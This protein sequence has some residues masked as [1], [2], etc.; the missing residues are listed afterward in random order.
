MSPSYLT[1]L[2]D[3]NPFFDWYCCCHPHMPISQNRAISQ[4]FSSPFTGAGDSG[5]KMLKSIQRT[6][7]ATEIIWT[8]CFWATKIFQRPVTAGTWITSIRGQQPELFHNIY[9]PRQI[10]PIH[11]HRCLHCRRSDRRLGADCRH[12]GSDWRGQQRAGIQTHCLR[13][14]EGPWQLGARGFLAAWIRI[15]SPLHHLRT[16]GTPI[17]IFPERIDVSVQCSPVTVGKIS[18]LFRF[19]SCCIHV[20]A[21][22]WKSGTPKWDGLLVY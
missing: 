7:T 21:C 9:S 13:R 11:N 3:L 14:F 10:Q 18:A 12:L 22:G 15:G 8:R 5:E 16:R 1:L 6:C 17:G 2:P 20:C 4:Y 19:S